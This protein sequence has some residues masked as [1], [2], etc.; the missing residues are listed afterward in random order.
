MSI[1][2]KQIYSQNLR[3]ETAIVLVLFKILYCCIS[4]FISNIWFCHGYT[5]KYVIVNDIKKLKNTNSCCQAIQA[6]KFWLNL[7]KF[8][9]QC[10]LNLMSCLVLVVLKPFLC[11]FFSGQFFCFALLLTLKL[12]CLSTL[13]ILSFCKLQKIPFIRP[14]YKQTSYDFF[15]FYYIAFWIYIVFKYIS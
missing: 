9:Q 12:I 8:I 4:I 6:A 10:N 7:V 15:Y 5:T 11:S 14:I 3:V 1:I 13:T 2:I